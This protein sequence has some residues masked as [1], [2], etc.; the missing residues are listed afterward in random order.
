MVLYIFVSGMHRCIGIENIFTDSHSTN[1]K[2]PLS[3]FIDDYVMF[4]IVQSRVMQSD[5]VSDMARKWA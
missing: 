5:L 3:P 4:V 2:Y 1:P